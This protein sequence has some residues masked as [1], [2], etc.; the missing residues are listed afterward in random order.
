MIIN[1]INLVCSHLQ[2]QTQ[3]AVATYHLYIAIKCSI[4]K[5]R[6]TAFC[7]TSLGSV[8]KCIR[9]RVPWRNDKI[10]LFYI[11]WPNFYVGNY[12]LRRDGAQKAFKLCNKFF[13]MN[14]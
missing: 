13:S 2:A 6:L 5:S 3:V 12:W 1:L 14:L 8:C 11:N 9:Q 7:N 10:N 4:H